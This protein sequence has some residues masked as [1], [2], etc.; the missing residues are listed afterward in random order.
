MPRPYR[1]GRRNFI[2]IGMAGGLSL[3][4]DPET[5]AALEGQHRDRPGRAKNV[6]VI[7]EQGG[8]SHT[9]TWDPKPDTLVQQL[10]PYKP[11]STSVPGMQFTE[12]LPYTS[13]VANKLSVIRSMHHTT[14]IANGHPKG[15]QYTLS[16][17]VPGG[18][19]EMPDIGSVV[20]PVSYTHLTLP[21]KA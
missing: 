14:G 19:L 18:P 6:L 15:T 11:I 17:H 2:G 5:L 12:L 4:S 8:M 16:G 7:L 20:A 3:L 13:K 10:S 21:T 9:D 1:L